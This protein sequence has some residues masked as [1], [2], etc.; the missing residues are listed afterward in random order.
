MSCFFGEAE[1]KKRCCIQI[2]FIGSIGTKLA[3]YDTL[4][5]SSRRQSKAKTQFK[6]DIQFF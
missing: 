2:I 3:K 1:E 4:E 5:K 6:D